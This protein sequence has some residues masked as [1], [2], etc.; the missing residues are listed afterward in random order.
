MPLFDLFPTNPRYFWLEPR[1]R[2]EVDM[3]A[4]RYPGVCILSGEEFLPLNKLAAAWVETAYTPQGMI[5]FLYLFWPVP[6]NKVW[7]RG[8]CG[9]GDE[10]L[11][12]QFVLH[13]ELG[14]R[15]ADW[16]ASADLS[17]EKVKAYKVGDGQVSNSDL[18]KFLRARVRQVKIW[19]EVISEL[20]SNFIY[21]YDS[22]IS[23][24]G[25]YLAFIKPS[26]FLLGRTKQQHEEEEGIDRHIKLFDFDPQAQPP[27]VESE[28]IYWV[29][30][31]QKVMLILPHLNVTPR[32]VGYYGYR[33]ALLK[34]L[35][36]QRPEQL[37]RWQAEAV[38][39]ASQG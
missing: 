5:A 23:P 24:E 4:K 38:Q 16:R 26:S 33:D 15:F 30:E 13:P 21:G 19:H 25:Y 10:R 34:Y 2:G 17:S 18:P 7:I 8:R 12:S 39:A 37:K 22:N 14:Q 27:V 28:G 32:V 11:T 1:S 20:W 29:Q 31:E 35:S 36:Q 3:I 9:F 6:E